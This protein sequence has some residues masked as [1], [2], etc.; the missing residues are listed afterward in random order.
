MTIQNNRGGL[1]LQDSSLGR[2]EWVPHLECMDGTFLSQMEHSIT[3]EVGELRGT[4][5]FPAASGVSYQ[6]PPN[7]PTPSLLPGQN[8][9]DCKRISW[10]MCVE[11]FTFQVI[12]N[13]KKPKTFDGP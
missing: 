7:Q 1:R 3:A 5:A 11:A 2:N 8:T 13:K 12:E 6:Q 9:P 10:F 4:A